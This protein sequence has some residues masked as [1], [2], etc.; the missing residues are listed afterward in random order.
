MSK[1]L[2]ETVYKQ[3]IGSDVLPLS[4]TYTPFSWLTADFSPPAMNMCFGQPDISNPHL[5]KHICVSF[6]I[7]RWSAF[8]ENFLGVASFFKSF[9]FLS[10]GCTVDSSFL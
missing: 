5:V 1:F 7:F 8:T 4:E 10:P 9:H 3:E 2:A 6:I